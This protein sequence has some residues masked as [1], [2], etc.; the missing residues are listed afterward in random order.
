MPKEV[1]E[2]KKGRNFVVGHG[3]LPP[4]EVCSCSELTISA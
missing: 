4:E 3:N 2:A 1:E